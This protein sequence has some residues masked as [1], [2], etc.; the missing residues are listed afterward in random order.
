[1]LKIDLHIHT[2]HSGHAYGTFYDVI[3]EAAKKKMKMIAIADHGPSL[4]G[5]VTRLHFGM[6]VRSPKTYKGVKILWGCE[7]DPVNGSGKL[8]L[9]DENIAKLDILLVGFHEP[10][11]YKDLGKKKNTEMLIKCFKRYKPQIFT[12]PAR[13]MYPYDLE[14]VCQAA[15]DNGVMLE[16]NLAELAYTDREK[17]KQ[18]EAR[19]K[20]IKQTVDI[21]RKNKKK[22]ILNSDAHFL[23][24]IGDDKILKKYAKK[25][26]VTKDI[27][28]NNY[29]KELMGVLKRRWG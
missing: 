19:L 9:S 22:M 20:R 2:I 5:S 4:L 8:D 1:M 16:L 25:L 29:P 17:P 10:T 21:A 28:I 7:S 18:R 15:C 13:Q 23:H 27:I 3:K 11:P 24:E 26:G 12:H 6:G 14:K